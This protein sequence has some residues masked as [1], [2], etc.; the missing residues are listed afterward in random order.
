MS[1]T[2]LVRGGCLF[3]VPKCLLHLTVYDWM[4][5]SY[6]CFCFKKKGRERELCPDAA[7]L[8]AKWQQLDIC[9]WGAYHLIHPLSAVMDIHGWQ[10]CSADE[11]HTAA[12]P[13]GDATWGCTSRRWVHVECS[14]STNP[15][16]TNKSCCL[17][18]CVTTWWVQECDAV[19]CILMLIRVCAP[20]CCFLQ[21]TRSSVLI[22]RFLLSSANVMMIKKLCWAHTPEGNLCWQFGGC[23]SATHVVVVGVYLHRTSC[24]WS[25]R[26]V[27]RIKSLSF[28]LSLKDTMV[29]T[30][31]INEHVLTY[32]FFCSR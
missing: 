10:L 1:R 9:V 12:V 7:V 11:G 6:C 26:Q 22:W 20:P 5:E 31:E 32:V 29:L 19:N 2:L 27:L 18:G 25:Q 8:S 13:G 28:I 30:N 15:H 16:S 17:A 24:I 21:S 4:L 23:G 14:H 3:S